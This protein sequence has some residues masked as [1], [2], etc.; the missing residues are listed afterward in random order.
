MRRNLLTGNFKNTPP[1][2]VVFWVRIVWE[3]FCMDSYKLDI[4]RIV[5]CRQVL[6]FPEQAAY[7][8][9]IRLWFVLLSTKQAIYFRDKLLWRKINIYGLIVTL[10]ELREGCKRPLFFLK[11]A[12]IKKDE[13]SQI[14][15]KQDFC[16]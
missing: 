4:K 9:K 7:T 6:L 1:Y 2:F 11:I 3:A 13:K 10:L 12:R 5:L 14:N 16:G 8:Y 15:T